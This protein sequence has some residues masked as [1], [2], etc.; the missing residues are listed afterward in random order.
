MIA[1]LRDEL[2][3]VRSLLTAGEIR[4]ATL[5]LDEALQELE[6]SRLLTTTEAAEILGIRS[7][8]TLKALV[9]TEDIQTVMHGN[10]L[11]I[12]LSEVERIHDSARVR[13][14]RAADLAHD[15]AE[16]LGVPEGMTQDEMDVLSASRPGTPPW[17]RKQERAGERQ[18]A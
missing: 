8:N 4:A 5:K 12:P 9:R 2:R 18:T 13:G 14:I 11:M 17:R 6:T 10:R 16:A 3:S 7:V 1:E 15:V